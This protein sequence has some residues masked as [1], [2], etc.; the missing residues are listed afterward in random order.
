MIGKTSIIFREFCTMII[1]F[2]KFLVFEKAK[3]EKI[4]TIVL[5]IMILGGQKKIIN[6]HYF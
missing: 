6:E 1:T 4:K 2:S 5:K 3:L